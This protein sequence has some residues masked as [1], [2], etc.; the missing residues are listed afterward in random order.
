M[1]YAA[2][3]GL[4]LIGPVLATALAVV[5]RRP[6]RRWWL[7]I[8]GTT[9]VLLVMTVLFDS[10]MIAADLFRFEESLLLGW[11][12]GLAPVEDLAWPLAAGLLLPSLWLLL[13]P[14]RER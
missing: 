9:A 8:A 2:L 5:L 14:E 10:L 3:A 1:T 4:F 6:G 7:L 11:R 13:T 12:I